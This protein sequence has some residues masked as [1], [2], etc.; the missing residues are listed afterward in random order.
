MAKK[1]DFPTLS[2][3]TAQTVRDTGMPQN[4]VMLPYT[5]PNYRLKTARQSDF[6][7]ESYSPIKETPRFM[8]SGVKCG[9][10]AH[11]IAYLTA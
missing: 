2:K 1:Q 9:T 8:P 4:I 5:I 10:C 6:I 7:Q 11:E 3:N